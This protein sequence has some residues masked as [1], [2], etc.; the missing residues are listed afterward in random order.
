MVYRKLLWTAIKHRELIFF[1]GSVA[2]VVGKEIL[3]SDE[4]KEAASNAIAN[5]KIIGHDAEAKFTEI[6][7]DVE[8]QFLDVEIEEPQ[9]KVKVNID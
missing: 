6:M 1:A 5:A 3:E 8:K 9:P 4:V 7:G 2:A